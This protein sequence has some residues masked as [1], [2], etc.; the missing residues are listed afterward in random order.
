MQASVLSGD[1][2]LPKYMRLADSIRTEIAL[3]K[4][5]PGDQIASE[6]ELAMHYGL[7]P[8]TVRQAIAILVEERILERKHGK[9]TFVR[10]P[11]FD[12]SMFRFFRFLGADGL[13]LEPESRIL[14][15]LLLPAPEHVA[16]ALS[17][18]VGADA[19]FMNRLR[20][21][22]SKPV[23]VEEIW[24]PLPRFSGFLEIE[25][26][27]IG[28][29]L[30]PVYDRECGQIVARA[31]EYLTAEAAG[32]EFSSILKVEPSEPVIVIERIA[33]SYDDVALEWRRSRG[34]AKEFNYHASI[35]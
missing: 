22:D 29:L 30:Y 10:H 19:I 26:R 1:D 8:G 28:P 14:R 2:R 31:E 24:L 32:V 23:L 6:T 13:D 15:R 21:V 7:A 5:R 9:G 34:L 18:D 12:S 20:L 11:R 35:R 27:E 33:Y 16:Q 25:K 17:I 4:R 3:G